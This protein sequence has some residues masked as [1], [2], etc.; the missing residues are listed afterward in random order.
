MATQRRGTQLCLRQ[1]VWL[2]EKMTLGECE[3]ARQEGVEQ[4]GFLNKGNCKCKGSEVKESKTLVGISKVGLTL[5]E[6][7]WHYLQGQEWKPYLGSYQRSAKVYDVMKV[8]D[9]RKLLLVRWFWKRKM[10]MEG[11]IERWL[12]LFICLYAFMFST[13]C[14]FWRR[15]W[16]FKKTSR[17]MTLQ[18][19]K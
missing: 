15:V 10:V 9:F 5:W 19:I 18:I 6:G 13:L 3:Q 16:V 14:R 2:A 11:N 1:R 12:F 17:T 4:M 8:A 7:K